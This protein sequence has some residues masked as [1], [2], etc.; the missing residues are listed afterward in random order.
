MFVIEKHCALRQPSR[1]DLMAMGS[2][3]LSVNFSQK[4]VYNLRCGKWLH[5]LSQ[6]MDMVHLYCQQCPRSWQV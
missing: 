6:Y 1:A 2:L 4:E 3:C 5:T